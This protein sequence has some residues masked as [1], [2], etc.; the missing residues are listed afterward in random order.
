[1]TLNNAISGAVPQFSAI[2]FGPVGPPWV[3]ADLYTDAYGGSQPIMVALAIGYNYI[4]Q[5]QPLRPGDAAEIKSSEGS[6]L[7][8]IRRVSQIGAMLFNSST[9][10]FGTKFSQLLPAT[11]RT[12][13]G[14]GGDSVPV[15]HATLFT[16]VYRD[17]ILDEGGFDGAVCWEI[18]RPYPAT[19]I[20]VT[21]YMHLEEP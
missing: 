17:T 16:G 14:A 11:L 5:G 9:I 3:Y 10:S 18:N 4:S 6:G 1:V 13:G 7:G 15:D 19:V 2:T 21:G 8:K 12:G 20:S